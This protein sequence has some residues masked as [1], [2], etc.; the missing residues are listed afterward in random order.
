LLW[1]NLPGRRV[2]LSRPTC[3]PPVLA[4]GSTVISS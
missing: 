4:G 2:F 3:L 1:P